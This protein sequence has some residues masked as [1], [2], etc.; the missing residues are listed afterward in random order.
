MSLRMKL[1]VGLGF[2]FVII[3]ALFIFSSY[4]IRQLSNDADKI[5][6]DNYNSLVYCKDMLIALDDMRT[7]A[8][9]SSFITNPSGSFGYDSQLFQ[10]SR[11]SFETNLSAEENNITE[12]H[13]KEYAADLAQKYH[14]FLSF[15][16]QMGKS[17]KATSMYA[18]DIQLAYSSARQTIVKIDDLNMQAIERKNL[19]AKHNA[20]NMTTT[21]L[22]VG[23]LLVI[24]A[25][26]YFWYFPFYVSHTVSYL[27]KKMKE[28][29]K[30]AGIKIDTRTSDEAFIL[31]QSIDLLEDKLAKSRAKESMKRGARTKT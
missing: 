19:T 30:N 22:V 31:L 14:L 4:D 7:A 17:G 5:L 8:N 16:Q 9:R 3:F 10:N 25:F 28:L 27:S 26:F 23:A 1:T 12:T 21:L 11:S 20:N 2:L 18:D 15:C 24:I 29:L 13:E 6:R